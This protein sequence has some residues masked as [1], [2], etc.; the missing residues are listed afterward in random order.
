M[1]I[2]SIVALALLVVVAV[3][4]YRVFKAIAEQMSQF[5]QPS[6]A[7]RSA[8]VIVTVIAAAVAYPFLMPAS[9]WIQ[10]CV[11]A[12]YLV[13]AGL[14]ALQVWE[15]CTKF[16]AF[17]IRERCANF[18]KSLPQVIELTVRLKEPT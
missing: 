11:W 4:A 9:M 13:F 6:R 3:G 5:C 15:S 10:V 17:R 14:G 7:R 18:R 1:P 8:F 12:L 2:L 16:G